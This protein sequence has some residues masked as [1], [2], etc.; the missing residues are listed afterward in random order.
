[1]NRLFFSWLILLL[2]ASFV[3]ADV[4]AYKEG[5][6]IVRF[7]ETGDS[8][9]YGL[10][11]AK[12]LEKAAMRN[13]ILTAAGGGSVRHTFAR[14]EGLSVVELPKGVSVEQALASYKQTPGVLYAQ[15]NYKLR[16]MARFPFDPCFPKLWGMHNTGQTGGIVDADIDAPEAWDYGTGSSDIV[17]AVIDTGINK[18]H[19]DLIANNIGGYDFVNDD[20]D[21]DDDHGHGTHVAGTIGAG[22]NNI[23]GVTGVCW[24]VKLMAVKAADIT[25]SL[26][27]DDIVD[28]IGY[29]ITNGADVI[30]ASWGASPGAPFDQAMYDAI[31]DANDA[32]VL[33]VAAAG[34]DYG[35]DNDANNVWPAGYD[36]DNII[37]VMATND[38]DLMSGFSNFGSNS[39]DLGAPGGGDGAPESD[40][41]SCWKGGSNV[42]AYDQGTSMA[43]PHVAGACALLYSMD[44]NLTADRVKE[45]ILRS[46]DLTLPG[47]C[48]S[49][50]RLNLERA[51]WIVSKPVLNKTQGV[52]HYTIQDAINDANDGDEIIADANNW[53]YQTIDFLGKEIILRSG[54]I[55]NPNDPNTSLNNTYISGLLD[56]GSVVT[57]ANVGPGAALKGFTIRDGYAIGP[58]WTQ[59]DNF[60]GG[61]FLDNAYPT[62]SDCNIID[63][64]AAWDGGGI[65]C[66]GNSSAVIEN[67]VIRDNYASFWGGGILCWESDPVIKNCLIINNTSQ[68]Q[69]GG[70]IYL[71]DSA[72][73]II[74][75]TISH[76]KVAN[77]SMNGGAVYCYTYSS[78]RPSAPEIINCIITKSG[79]NA[80]YEDGS[81]SDPNVSHCLLYDNADGDYYDFDTDMVLNVEDSDPNNPLA[82][83]NNKGQDPL[84]VTG[85]LGDYYLSQTAAGQVSQSP[86][87]D[88]GR[89]QAND[90][91]IELHLYTTRTDTLPDSGT[92][93]MGYHYDD[94]VAPEMFTLNWD[95]VPPGTGSIITTPAGPNHVKYSQVLLEAV[96][97]DPCNY[98]FA[99]WNGTDDDS[100]TEPNNIV[101]MDSDKTVT[102]AFQTRIVSLHVQVTSGSGEVTL[103][104]PPM[105]PRLGTYVRGTVVTITAIPS[106]PSNV[107][108]WTGTDNDQTTV[109]TN[110]VTMTEDKDV[111]IEFYQPQILHFPGDYPDP[112]GLQQAIDDAHKGDII[113]V[114]RGV[115]YTQSGYWVN[116]PITISSTNPE[117]PCCVAD[118]VIQL[119]TAG[120]WSRAF[121][122]S[123]VGTDTILNGITFKEF[124]GKGRQGQAGNP[125]AD[126]ATYDGE[127][128][129]EVGG[130]AIQCLDASPKIKNCRFENCQL[131]GGDGGLGAA[132]I[133]GNPPDTMPHP[134]GGHG[135]W[136]GK[137]LGGAIRLAAGSDPCL[138]KCTFIN[139]WAIGGNGGDGGNGIEDPWGR[140][141]RGGGWY[142]GP[143][144]PTEWG[145]AGPPS[146]F[147]GKGGA[148]YIDADSS[149]TIKYC[150]FINCRSGGGLNGICG[151]NGEP[152]PFTDEPSLRYKIPSFGGAVYCDA[153]SSPKII[154][155]NFI[156]N[157]T[158]PCRPTQAADG[159]NNNTPYV[160]Y[161]GGIAFDGNAAPE[162]IDCNFSGNFG[163]VGGAIW[164]RRSDSNIVDCNFTDNLA[165]QGG[166]VVVAGGTAQILRSNFSRNDS[167]APYSKGGA[168]SSLGAYTAVVDCD[169][170]ANSSNGSGGGVYISS[171]GIDGGQLSDWNFVLL[172]NCIITDNT[173]RRDGAGVSANWYSDPYILNCTIANNKVVGRGGYGGGLF[174]SYSNYSYILNSIIW[175]NFAFNGSQIAA[176]S[177]DFVHPLPSTVNISYSHVGPAYDP[178]V[179]P[180]DP[181]GDYYRYSAFQPEH[182]TGG[183]YGVD[184]YVGSD[185]IDRIIYYNDANAYIYTVSIPEGADEHMHP[186][187]SASTGPVAPRTFTLELSFDLGS[188]FTGG[189][190]DNFNHQCEFYVDAANNEIYLGAYDGILKYVYEYD[191]DEGIYNYVYDSTVAPPPNNLEEEW[192]Q[193]LAYDPDTRTWYTGSGTT[194]RVWKY[195][196]TQGTQGQWE[197]AFT[198]TPIAEGG[199]H[200]GMEFINGYLF[201]ADYAGDHIQQFTPD[202]T[203]IDIY[204]HDQ[205][206]H[207]VEGLGWGALHHFWAGSHGVAMEGPYGN[208]ITEFGGGALQSLGKV[209]GPPIYLEADCVVYG[210][211]PNSQTWDISRDNKEDDPLFITGPLGDYYLSQI[212]AGQVVDSNCVDTGRGLAESVFT[213]PN[214]TTRT[215]GIID[216][217]EVDR[218]YHYAAAVSD[219]QFTLNIFVTGDGGRLIG[220][221]G[222]SDPFVIEDPCSRL[223]NQATVVSLEAVPDP[224]YRVKQWTGTDNDATTGQNNTVTMDSDKTVIV[225]FEFALPNLTIHVIGAGTVTPEPEIRHLYPLGKVVTIT[226][227]PAHSTDVVFWSGTDNDSSRNLTN[228]VTI[229]GNHEVFIEFYTPNIL[230]FPGDYTELQFAIDS[231][232]DG[233]KVIIDPDVYQT[234]WG[235]DVDNKA[236]TIAGTNPDDPCVV[237]ATVIELEVGPQGTVDS[238]FTFRDVGRDTILEGLTIRGF[239]GRGGR[240]NDG[241]PPA[242]YD[243]IRGGTVRGMGVYCWQAASPTIRN[244]RFVDCASIGGDGGNG[245]GGDDDHPTGGNGGWGGGAEGGAI[246]FG[247][248]S[249][250]CVFGCTFIECEALG[251]SGGDGGQ[252]ND[253]P[254][255]GE[256][257]RGGGYYYP[258][259]V[260]WEDLTI[261]G[262][263]TDYTGRGAAIFLDIGCSATI[264]ECTFINCHTE[265]GNNGICGL[266]GGGSSRDEPSLRWKIPNYGGAIFCD[267]GSSPKILSCDFIDNLGDPNRPF[268]EPNDPDSYDNKT[269]H[270][271]YG[272]AIAFDAN[273]TPIVQD[274]NFA[275]NFGTIGGAIYAHRSQIEIFDCNFRDNEAYHG[276]G[277]VLA[278]GQGRISQCVIRDNDANLIDG[279]GGGIGC[280]GASAVIADC[281]ITDNTTAGSGGGVYISSR[282]VE[283]ENMTS[284]GGITLNNCLIAGNTADRDGGGISANWNTDPEI[285]NCT[286]VNNTVT[287]AGYNRGKG[288]GIY[289]SSGSFSKIANSIIWANNADDGRQVA[290][291]TSYMPSIVYIFYSDVRGGGGV[292]Q[293][294]SFGGNTWLDNYCTLIWDSTSDPNYPTNLAGTSTDDPL[295][296]TGYLGDYYLSQT[297][298]NELQTED[299]PCV[300][301]GLSLADI[302]PLGPYRYTTRTD[303]EQDTDRIDI[304]YH[305]LKYGAYTKGD[306]NYD[307]GVNDIDLFVLLSHWLQECDFPGWCQGADLNKDGIVN[308]IDVAILGAA[309]GQGDI[310]PPVPNPMTW[311]LPP[312]SQS[313][314]SI[315]MIASRAL[316]NSGSDVQYYFQCVTN[317]SFDSGWQQDQVYL[318][319][320]LANQTQ[321]G[322]RV[323]A[324]DT[325][326]LGQC[327][328]DDPDDPD[329]PNKTDWSYI[330]YAV[331]G[332]EAN[333][334]SIDDHTP[335][336]PDP[337][338]WLIDPNATGPNSIDMTAVVATDESGV[339][340]YFDCITPGCHDSGWQNST[341]YEDTGL[342]PLTAYAYVVRAHDNSIWYNETG[343]SDVVFA[344]TLEQGVIPDTNAPEPDPPLWEV[345]PHEVWT[346]IEDQYNAVMTAAE[347][348][349]PEGGTVQYYF[350]CVDAPIINSGWTD[351]RTVSIYIGRSHQGLRFHFKT[352][353]EFGNE[354][355]WSDAVICLP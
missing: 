12:P 37:A 106:N 20:A 122:F 2:L 215:D 9:F 262:W 297:D 45:F 196:A 346:G 19:L 3:L 30:N 16:I 96:A 23:T 99:S 192:I 136:P 57:I 34:N 22:G 165:Y 39:V 264:E 94:T 338:E 47:L 51:A 151:V 223:V 353:D 140:G 238:A 197:V 279:Q 83:K 314:S 114:D 74:N 236:I 329:A 200:D 233:D 134:D 52:R 144:F 104:P 189:G 201:L 202:G 300:D 31:A 11:Q 245:G 291:A 69:D 282:D 229:T 117:D 321:Y 127:W 64:T 222:G 355:G 323:R 226:A 306:L 8:G 240:G 124:I 6:L 146:D 322:F 103:D 10:K 256:G 13:S 250:P 38:H 91:N 164:G 135:G 93:D 186:D 292:V 284:S 68:S 268:S 218:G 175:N 71:D 212:A 1:M 276:A 253:S 194:G 283:G 58:L 309:Y 139:C 125:G 28:A 252:G 260:E 352:S 310:E 150:T 33:F 149:P 280:L 318:A 121:V 301:K 221:G 235:F 273:S 320:G 61:I 324:K 24:T 334:P 203:L 179:G 56:E 295:F 243:G 220:Q 199:H 311:T 174:S 350:E 65:Y 176:G 100:R 247:E 7:D 89:G 112:A 77:Q 157:L 170:T 319:E 204:Y 188:E 35:N 267:D 133:A 216:A 80:I 161:G 298:A 248:N 289:T 72:P 160:G 340:Y 107:V 158:D 182:E 63:N 255:W 302:L 206:D 5:E 351:E 141:G 275:G 244:C 166:G 180:I 308:W 95:V 299:S 168:I 219:Q 278:G 337:M 211:D 82:G 50:G 129:G 76:N 14:I 327:D 254:N 167:N 277:I 109:R 32:G 336:L 326:C 59:G 21:P 178:N 105:H 213:E 92:V 271:S 274:C 97:A 305:Y 293:A 4:S 73:T 303:N 55:E 87:V 88:T 315:I 113:I 48:L 230:H 90:P 195:D 290:I 198:Y 15:P 225:D 128:G 265:G 217:N 242:Y 227:T 131:E 214:Y 207:E 162:I 110:T 281:T 210:W 193:S 41:Y 354:S 266:G 208:M 258:Y 163:T 143:S 232:Q 152:F 123:N 257:G 261:T 349:D 148:V 347:A 224:N 85:R 172:K 286:I 325:K 154:G 272:G 190:S 137:A 108:I 185:G 269:P 159:Y 84:F 191:V 209:A 17:V 62:I 294:P 142:Y 344:T 171:T 75:C 246:Y 331:A 333:V 81:L 79:N 241:D 341:F 237:A 86:A 330:V 147:T 332:E 181:N 339:Q 270:V 44:P 101:T 342:E 119:Q 169:I 296:V 25:G 18:L 36:L 120:Q 343:D 239:R 228:T 184:G 313:D 285:I 46:V 187:N 126:P 156:D 132:G 40:I 60:G 130:A 312:T 98:E 317:S 111:E 53:Y 316:D 116:K 307:G 102:A 335:P 54:D 177:G 345:P 288:G 138:I 115:Y 251:G 234:S 49:N 27:T 26:A 287:G 70:G 78:M 67:C 42:Y 259:F 155:C 231:A 348:T 263:P 153:N 249:D 43:T 173:A 118:T 183:S 205:F 29:A 145:L 304:G 66:Q 328:P